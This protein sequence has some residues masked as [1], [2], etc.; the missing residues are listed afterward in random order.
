[1]IAVNLLSMSK[2]RPDFTMTEIAIKM[3]LT[4]SSVS[5][6]LNPKRDPRLSTLRKLSRAYG[7]T[8]EEVAE[9]YI[10]KTINDPI[11]EN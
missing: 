11:D 7:I 4:R 3:N 2:I 6:L 1:M 9:N 8:I 10:D 5:S